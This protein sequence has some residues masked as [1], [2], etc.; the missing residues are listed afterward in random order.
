MAQTK[1]ISGNVYK[2]NGAMT[3][4]QAGAIPSTDAT[5]QDLSIAE[6]TT[7]NNLKAQYGSKVVRAVSAVSSGNLGTIMPIAGGTFAYLNRS[8]FISQVAG[9]YI[10]GVATTL[11]QSP[12]TKISQ[13]PD[14]RLGAVHTAFLTVL[15]WTA[16]PGGLP[17]Y[18]KTISSQ[19]PNFGTDHALSV[20][21]EFAYRT[22]KPT[23]VQA[24]YIV[25]YSV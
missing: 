6:L 3:I 19:A 18:T 21:A 20:P 4:A 10:N 23:V 9:R 1:C 17:T 12:S 22:G 5:K 8:Q 25:P 16:N 14:N 15:T 11:F 2:L 13:R 7:N 24:D